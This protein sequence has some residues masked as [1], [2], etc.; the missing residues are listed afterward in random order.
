MSSADWQDEARR[1]DVEAAAA[2][3]IAGGGVSLSAIVNDLERDLA[4]PVIAGPGALMWAA[5]KRLGRSGGRE[6]RG[7]L[8]RAGA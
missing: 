2:L 6:D 4:K 8:F 3:A 5:L 1:A 7:A